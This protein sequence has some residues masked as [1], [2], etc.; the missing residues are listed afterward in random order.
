MASPNNLPQQL[1]SFVGREHEIAEVKRLLAG[2]RLLTL[3]GTGGCGKTRLALQVATGSLEEYRD[4]VWFVD[5]APLSDP[6][7]VPQAVAFALGVSEKHAR[8]LTDILSEYLVSRNLLLVLDNCEQVLDA[9]VALADSLLRACP[10]LHILATSRHV[11]GVAGETT[12]RVP[13]LSLPDGVH[14]PDVEGLLQYEAIQL[15]VERARLKRPG[16][17]VT[18]QNATYIVQLCRRLDGIPLAIELAA[19]RMS[20][21]ALEQVV[22]RL[23]E[24]F[25]LLTEGMGAVLPRQQTLRAAIDWS[26]DLL[27]EPEQALLR[28]LSIFSGSFSLEAVEG[29]CGLDVDEYETLNLMSHMVDKSLVIMGVRD[30]EARYR[31]LETIRQYAWEKLHGSEEMIELRNLHLHWYM[32]L[33]ERAKPELQG[34]NQKIWLDRVE[35]EHDN[36]RAALG[37]SHVSE[38]EAEAGLRLAVALWW[39]W[40]VRGYLSEGRRWLEGVLATSSTLPILLRAK[41]LYGTGLLTRNQGDSSRA[42]ALFNESLVL[43]QELEDKDNISAVLA[44][45]GIMASDQGNYT[46]GKALLTESLGLQQEL[47]NKHRVANLLSNLANIATAQGDYKLAR[48]YLEESLTIFRELGNAY[49]LAISLNNLGYLVRLQGDCET[50]RSFIEESM[51]LKRELGDKVGIASS[52]NRLGEVE[53]SCRNYS[54]ARQF[55]EESL[56]L[57]REVGEK[58]AVALLL[59]NLGE[60][61]RCQGNYSEACILYKQALV[62]SREFGAEAIITDVL[63]N[64][65]HVAQ[66]Q[67]DYAQAYVLFLESLDISGR[68]GARV[69]IAQCLLGLA[70]LATVYGLPERAAQLFGAAE[71]LFEVTGYKLH[72]DDNDEYTHN[73]DTTRSQLSKSGWDTAWAKGYAMSLDE[74]VALASL[75]IP[76]QAPS[77]RG[78]MNH[79]LAPPYPNDLTKREVEVLRLVADGLTN[80]QVAEQLFLSSN[81]VRAHLH[82]IYGKLNVTTRGAA[83]R[84]ALKHKLT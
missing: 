2:A 60:I 25:R 63:Y 79:A 48:S 46:Q 64:L 73:T 13:P 14:L 12:W 71:M 66:R 35:T 29:I 75:T 20:V 82:S 16:F 44:N 41:A 30:G 19:A 31:V 51:T 11:L 36:M 38:D 47:G 24:R 5:L 28:R 8:P 18:P 32:G 57:F 84:F 45:L 43:F 77:S 83:S 1:T 21:L 50:A 42:T 58:E 67:G 70:G 65:G 34:P 33:A 54:V 26:Y 40:Y 3:T 69:S 81:T 56:D 72:P 22:N 52:L 55:Y 68:L 76:A 62:V 6:A 15:F 49:H 7:L 37:W 61:A 78:V 4:G 17:E 27:N 39:F 53:W 9:C 80:E 23:D 59:N 74:A 10:D